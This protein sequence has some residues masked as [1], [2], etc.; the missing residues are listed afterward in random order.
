[1]RAS[2]L[3]KDDVSVIDVF[4]H[5]T[6]RLNL[7]FY[8]LATGELKPCFNPSNFIIDKIINVTIRVDTRFNGCGILACTPGVDILNKFSGANVHRKTCVLTFECWP[9]TSGKHQGDV[10]RMVRGYTGFEE[11]RVAIE[12]LAVEY[13]D[14][15][16]SAWPRDHADWSLEQFVESD[17]LVKG[18]S[19]FR[20]ALTSG[21]GK[22]ELGLCHKSPIPALIFRP[23]S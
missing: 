16:G 8:D 19:A 6:C 20:K 22:S 15:S 7:N 9:G 1:M 23:R 4:E 14:W 3:I 10:L 2:S 12:Y 13:R 17:S 5:G 21:L 18:H 11:V